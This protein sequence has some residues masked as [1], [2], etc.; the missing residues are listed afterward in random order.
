MRRTHPTSLRAKLPLY[1]VLLLLSTHCRCQ[2]EVVLFPED[3]SMDATEDVESSVPLR[4]FSLGTTTDTTRP[5]S[6]IGTAFSDTCP[7][8][9]V[10]VGVNGHVQEDGFELLTAVSGTCATVSVGQNGAVTTNV[11]GMLP[12]HGDEEFGIPF[13]VMCPANQVAVGFEG[14]AGT[15]IDAMTLRCAPISVGG[16]MIAIGAASPVLP[17]PGGTMGT[18]YTVSCPGGTLARGRFGFADSVLQSFG[19]HCAVP[20]LVTP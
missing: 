11:Q 9:Q 2:Y 6:D 17:G 15:A 3:G 4:T 12:V 7:G 19:L 13:S 5:G 20:T 18:P 10:L 1:G 8:D 14:N 16:T